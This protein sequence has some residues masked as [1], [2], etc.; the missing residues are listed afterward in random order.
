MWES[1]EGAF[2]GFLGQRGGGHP[3]HSFPACPAAI[4]PDE[5]VEAGPSSLALLL[6]S[7]FLQH[8]PPPTP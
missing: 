2:Q 4:I 5:D 7:N 6:T 1:R 8:E 3:E